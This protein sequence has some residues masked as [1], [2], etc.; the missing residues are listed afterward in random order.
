MSHSCRRQWRHRSAAGRRLSSVRRLHRS[1]NLSTPSSAPSSEPRCERCR[2]PHH[3]AQ[4]AQRPALPPLVPV[5][6]IPRDPPGP[7]SPQCGAYTSPA[8]RS[9]RHLHASSASTRTCRRAAV[10]DRRSHGFRPDKFLRPT[11]GLGAAAGAIEVAPLSCGVHRGL[12]YHAA[13]S[14][15]PPV[16]RVHRLSTIKHDHSRF[17]APGLFPHTSQHLFRPVGAKKH[18]AQKS[19]KS[20][21]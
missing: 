4:L 10:S 21:I 2:S 1:P 15:R 18:G 7:R 5:G 3:A 17:R 11:H 12:I 20:A 9:M 6:G 8:F 19:S 16:C 13:P 14:C